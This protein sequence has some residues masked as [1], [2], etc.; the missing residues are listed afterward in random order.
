[1]KHCNTNQ[2]P[3]WALR[4]LVAITLSIFASLSYG[5]EPVGEAT[6]GSIEV[7]AKKSAT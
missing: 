3:V 2:Q 6:L 5:A 1:M 4:P 7:T